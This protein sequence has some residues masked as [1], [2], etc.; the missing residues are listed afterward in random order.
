MR[1][2]RNRVVKVRRFGG[3]DGLEVVDAPLPTAGWGEVRV[4]VLASSVQYT[5]VLI[6]RHL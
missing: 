2:P 5:D 6:R 4:R 3:P 1:D